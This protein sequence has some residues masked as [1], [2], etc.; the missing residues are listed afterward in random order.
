MKNRLCQ[1]RYL[2]ASSG[3]VTVL[4][5]AD[6][7]GSPQYVRSGLG[8]RIACHAAKRV[9]LDEAVAPEDR[10]RAIKQLFDRLVDRHM[11]LRPFTEGETERMKA[12]QIPR[13]AYGTTLLA[14]RLTGDSSYFLHLGD[15]ELHAVRRDGR[16]FPRINP[17]KGD[18]TGGVN[19]LVQDSACM[20]I[21]TGLY[22]EPAAAVVLFTDGYDCRQSRPWPVLD[23]CAGAV[24]DGQIDQLLDAGDCGGD[25][26]TLVLY[27]DEQACADGAY[28]AGLNQERSRCQLLLE[29]SE[30]DAEAAGLLAYL[31]TMRDKI[32]GLSGEALERK[33]QQ[34]A[35][36]FERLRRCMD[37]REQL[38]GVLQDLDRACGA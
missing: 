26:Q 4:V 23:L 9:L 1:D 35:P 7:H 33:K 38:L 5:V 16:F 32:R 6:G 36:R 27:A 29:I 30:L 10:P 11:Q 31:Q 12:L 34:A 19:S 8:A 14:A 2:V 18:F 13:Y 20:H 24:S 37:R 15:G 28:T 25:D 22:R 17:E 3:D 21:H